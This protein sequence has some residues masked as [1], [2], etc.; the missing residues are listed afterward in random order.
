V[1]EDEAH[2]EHTITN[3][4][5][6]YRVARGSCDQSAVRGWAAFAK[7]RGSQKLHR[8]LFRILDYATDENRQGAVHLDLAVASGLFAP[9]W[10]A[11]VA[12]GALSLWSGGSSR[13]CALIGCNVPC[14]PPRRTCCGAHRKQ[15]SEH[16][17][18]DRG[19]HT[20]K[21]SPKSVRA[22]S[23]GPT[24]FRAISAAWFRRV[25]A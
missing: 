17:E 6:D 15:I 14:R 3:Y 24:R 13:P 2:C 9:V 11:W 19:P 20:K 21:V 18:R 23:H 10:T 8:N 25:A 22:R 7:G 4:C 12:S 5:A 1:G 16:P